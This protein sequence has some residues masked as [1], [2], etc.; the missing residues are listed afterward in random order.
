MEVDGK[1]LRFCCEHYA[2]NFLAKRRL[3]STD[4]VFKRG[5]K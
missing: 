2:S 1:K 4:Q 3:E 5:E